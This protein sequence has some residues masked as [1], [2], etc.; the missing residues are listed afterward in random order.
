MDETWKLGECISDLGIFLSQCVQMEGTQGV[1]IELEKCV[2]RYT[3]AGGTEQC[4]Y[5]SS[6]LSSRSFWE[7]PKGNLFS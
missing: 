4:L 5:L 3:H 2:T 7:G 1:L 6:T